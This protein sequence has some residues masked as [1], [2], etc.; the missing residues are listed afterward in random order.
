MKDNVAIANFN[1]IFGEKEEPLLNYFREIVF[2]AFSSNIVRLRLGADAK[3]DKYYFMDVKVVEGNP[4]DYILTGKII[5]ETTLEIK[6]KIKDQKLVPTDEK[7]PSAP[8]SVFYIY[9]KNHR[10]I[11]IKNQKGSPDIKTFGATARYI[12]AEYIV[13]CNEEIEQINKTRNEEE[14]LDY[15]PYVR[16]NIV[17]IPMKEDLK[18]ALERVSKIKKLSLR[19]YPLNGDL[20]LSPLIEGLSNDLREKVGSKTGNIVLN[21]PTSKSGVVEVI[22]ASQGVFES[23]LFV[24]YPDK[25]KDV[26]TNDEY[27]GKTTWGYSEKEINNLEDIKESFYDLDS[28][29]TVSDGNLEIYEKQKSSIK[30]VIDQ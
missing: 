27:S 8:Y 10:M 22:D 30:E 16:L 28:M 29:K 5:K 9:L 4:D 6:S 19:M 14:Q 23:K 25:S 7:Y 17:G 21:S 1:V 12:M 11:L 2:P 13:K 3:Y 24:E 26:I 18:N 20:N 15:Y